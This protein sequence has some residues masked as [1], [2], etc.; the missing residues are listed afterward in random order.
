MLV[1]KVEVKWGREEWDTFFLSCCSC[2]LSLHCYPLPPT[3]KSWCWSFRCVSLSQ[4]YCLL[5]TNKILF[6]VSSCILLSALQPVTPV[7]TFFL[8]SHKSFLCCSPS[9]Y[10]AW[11]SVVQ[12]LNIL[13]KHLEIEIIRMSESLGFFYGS[14]NCGVDILTWTP[15]PPSVLLQC[16]WRSA[17]ALSRVFVMSS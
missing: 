13:F 14:K 12:E 10:I 4:D 6:L 2:A 16:L 5:L 3:I 11:C 9:R 8:V 15:D 7:A 1:M 17:G